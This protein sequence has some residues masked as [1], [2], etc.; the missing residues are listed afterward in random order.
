MKRESKTIDERRGTEREG[1][2]SERR[3]VNIRERWR[4]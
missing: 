4:K 2:V 3:G 1:I